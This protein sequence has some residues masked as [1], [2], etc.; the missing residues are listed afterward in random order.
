MSTQQLP[1][2]TRNVEAAKRDMDDFGYTIIADALS[3][4]T[5]DAMV[6]RLYEQARGEARLAGTTLDVTGETSTARVFNL[7]NKGAVWRAMIDPTDEVH[8]VFE[9]VF[10]PCFYPP[11]A[12]HG[13]SQKYL[14]SST[15]AKFKHR[16]EHL[17]EPHFHTDQK[18]ANGHQD[19]PLVCTVF[20]CLSDFNKENGCTMV[21]PGSHKIP[22][23][24][25]GQYGVEAP[26]MLEQAVYMEVPAGTAFIFEGR[27]WHSEGVNTSGEVRI[28]LNGYHCAPYIRQRELFAMNL[29]QDVLDELTDE[30]LS[31]LGFDAGFLF[32]I[33]EPTLGRSNVGFTY[34]ESVE[35]FD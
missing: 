11:I 34:P 4:D 2:P 13:R 29:R 35:L 30:Q 5:V 18:W 1:A 10:D 7:L 8:Q 32:N 14:L 27:T 28:H 15:G 33:I 23:P 9:H 17:T 16:D 24:T 26:E 31:L 6:D 21:V 3:K 12:A 19:Y 25:M 22:S 20:F